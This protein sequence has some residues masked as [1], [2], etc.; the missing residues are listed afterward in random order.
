MIVMW[1]PVEKAKLEGL[2]GKDLDRMPER[3]P[4]CLHWRMEGGD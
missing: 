2:R 4:E 1:D 3:G